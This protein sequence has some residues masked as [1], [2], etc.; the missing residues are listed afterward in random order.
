MSNELT[1]CRYRAIAGGLRLAIRSGVYPPG[2]RLRPELVP[3]RRDGVRARQTRQALDAPGAAVPPEWSDDGC[4]GDAVGF[5]LDDAR[6][7][8]WT[9][10]HPPRPRAA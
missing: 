6:S 3:A 5:S 1:T 10:A 7:A 9:V 8:G 4:R 2:S